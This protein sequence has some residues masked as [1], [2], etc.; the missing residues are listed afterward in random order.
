M[1]FQAGYP[2]SFL[3]EYILLTQH[4]NQVYHHKGSGKMQATLL[5]IISQKNTMHK[6]IMTTERKTSKL[7]VILL[8]IYNFKITKL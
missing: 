4:S 3:L 5:S 8:H 6:N 2:S 1:L 7:P